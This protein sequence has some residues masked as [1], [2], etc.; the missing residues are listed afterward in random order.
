MTRFQYKG[1]QGAITRIFCNSKDLSESKTVPLSPNC[2][3]DDTI[4]AP[5]TPEQFGWKQSTDESLDFCKPCRAVYMRKTYNPDGSVK[6][7][8]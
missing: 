4:A 3:K 1:E 5:G 7:N 8:P 2:W 6:E